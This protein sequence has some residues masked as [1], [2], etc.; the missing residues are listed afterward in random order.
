[1]SSGQANT[2]LWAKRVAVLVLAGMVLGV[3]ATSRAAER[4]AEREGLILGAALGGGGLRTQDCLG[5]SCPASDVFARF[6]T[7]NLKLGWMLSPRMAAL[8]YVPAGLHV[9]NDRKRAFEGV[10]VGLQYWIT[11]RAWVQGG[12]GVALDVPLLFTKPEG[13]HAGPGLSAG[14]G[15]DLVQ[16][17]RFAMD[18]QVR[19]LY[20][21]VRVEDEL[22]RRSGATDILVGFNW[23]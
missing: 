4:P 22:K 21:R 3:P 20:G 12:G 19:F 5:G 6:S 10:L 11:E 15:V 16:R 17:G 8:L 23:Y 14:A 13:F 7:P 1:M 18:L 9:R 2:G